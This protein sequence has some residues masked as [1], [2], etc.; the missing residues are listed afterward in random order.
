MRFILAVFLWVISAPAW[1]GV[2]CSL[3]F[4]IQNGQPADASQVMANYNALVTCLNNAAAAGANSDITSLNGLTTPIPA[5]GGGST[6]YIGATSGGAANVQTIAST[7]PTFV[8]QAGSMVKFKVGISNTAAATLN[9]AGTGAFPLY[10]NSQLG[11]TSSVG[12]EL[13]VGQ[14]ATVIY[15]GT[16]YQCLS[17]G[18]YYVG[19]ILDVFDQTPRKGYLYAD[20]SCVSQTT[21][22]DLF[23]VIGSAGIGGVSCASG[24]FALPDLRGSV[25]A[26][27]DNQGVNG[28]AGRLSNCG[29][30]TAFGDTCGSQQQTLGQSNLPSANFTVSG[31]TLTDDPLAVSGVGSVNA[32]NTSVANN[33]TGG[34]SVN[35]EITSHGESS[36]S[37]NGQT[38]VNSPQGS[39]ASGGSGTPFST[40][41]PLQFDY[42]IIKY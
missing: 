27:L 22:A 24:F 21:Y 20:G 19:Q 10:R 23:A 7:V 8:L 9:V 33:C 31:I 18:Q 39:A 40:I 4:N 13:I 3:P 17:C 28:D 32:C 36:N 15:D 6:A 38:A 14:M 2:S 34:S 1:A 16:N 41:Q 12:G 5:T 25:T 37:I 42:K 30:D 11:S 29:D 35:V 26:A